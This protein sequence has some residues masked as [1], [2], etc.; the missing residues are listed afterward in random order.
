[1]KINII[2][3]FACFFVFFLSCQHRKKIE[4]FDNEAFKKDRMA[5]SGKREQLITD[6]ERIRKEIKGM[7][8]TDVVGYLGRPDLEKLSDRGQ[9]YFVYFLQKGGQCISRDSSITARTAVLRFN[10]M[11]F[12]T[13]VGY[14]T[15]V[16]K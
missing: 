15:G 7:Y 14:E 2:S 13:E 9:K 4:N 12:V 11:E 5:C 6:F 10:A 1:M 8:V 16:P 3:F